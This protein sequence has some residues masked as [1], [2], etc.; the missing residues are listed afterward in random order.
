MFKIKGEIGN[1]RKLAMTA[2]LCRYSRTG[3]SRRCTHLIVKEK[4]LNEYTPK[5][6]QVRLL[7][8]NKS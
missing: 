6:A 2:M 4:T 7:P 5:M 8:S 3:F 1:I